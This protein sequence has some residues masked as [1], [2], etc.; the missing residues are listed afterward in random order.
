MIYIKNRKN[1]N[2][3]KPKYSRIFNNQII[4]GSKGY[5]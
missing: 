2:E 5:E 3:F 4:M 1:V